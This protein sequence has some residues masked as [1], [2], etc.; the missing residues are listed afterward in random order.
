MNLFFSRRSLVGSRGLHHPCRRGVSRDP[1]HPGGRGC[2]PQG[3]IRVLST[4]AVRR[5]HRHHR[6]SDPA[7][8]RRR[9]GGCVRPQ[10]LRER[11]R[12][13]VIAGQDGICERCSK[14]CYSLCPRRSASVLL[15]PRLTVGDRRILAD[16]RCPW[17]TFKSQWGHYF[18]STENVSFDPAPAALLPTGCPNAPKTVAIASR[19]SS[20]LTSTYRIVV[21]CRRGP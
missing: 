21:E 2:A 15:G 5:R 12:P 20:L 14:A 18:S 16:R 10:L 1:C 13:L 6:L 3:A 11:P 9:R 19:L 4:P 8:P 7:Q 17:N